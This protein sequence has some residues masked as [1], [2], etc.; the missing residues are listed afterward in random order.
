MFNKNLF[1]KSFVIGIIV[2][3]IGASIAPVISGKINRNDI[4]EKTLNTLSN[5]NICSLNFH[6]F[7]K[8]EKK[9][10]NVNLPTE[11]ANNIYNKLEELKYMIV[12]KPR[13]EETQNLK[14]EFVDLLDT[15]G[16]IPAGLTK[17]YVLSLL[18]PSWLKN[19]QKTPTTKTTLSKNY[20]SPIIEK[21][22]YLQQIFKNSFGK[23][24]PNI[25]DKNT[26][27][28]P[29]SKTNTT[30]T[31]CKISSGGSGTTLPPF[32]I[33]RPRAIAGWAAYEAQTMIAELLTAKL[34][35]AKGAQSG[36]MLGFMGI[37]L[38]WSI[39]GETMTYGLVGYA[40]YT[41]VSADYIEIIP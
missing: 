16:L 32:L 5:Q 17:N 12:Y 37:G 7:D 26:I 35:V 11:A 18:N 8:T 2:L 15:Y 36:S 9:Q 24:V 3:F 14:I 20:I 39:P 41:K 30:A 22:L 13:S 28:S 6:I 4:D 10:N 38:S 1:K 27:I 29:S 31:F 23:T 25:F 40:V 19:K 33:P 34:I 21:I